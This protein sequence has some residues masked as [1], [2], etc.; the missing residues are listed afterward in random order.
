MSNWESDFK[1]VIKV[2]ISF[3]ILIIIRY[4]G[5]DT[6][7]NETS[8]LTRIDHSVIKSDIQVTI[9]TYVCGDTPFKNQHQHIENHNDTSTKKANENI[10]S[11]TS[12]WNCTPTNQKKFCAQLNDTTLVIDDLEKTNTTDWNCTPIDQKNYSATQDETTQAFDSSKFQDNLTNSSNI[13]SYLV[14]AKNFI[15]SPPE[16]NDANESSMDQFVGL[17]N[18]LSSTKTDFSELEISK[19]TFNFPPIPPNI[20]IK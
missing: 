13:S 5:D 12:E 7:L 2:F 1:F 6:S 4:N 11:N 10:I 18:S 17:H 20:K 8:N 14:G 15:S 16:I 9:S 3:I 19:L